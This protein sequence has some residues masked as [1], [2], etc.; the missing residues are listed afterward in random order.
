MH[1][2]S[3]QDLRWVKIEKIKEKVICPYCG[4]GQKIQYT[5]DAKCWGVYVKCQARHCKKEFE[6]K[7]NADK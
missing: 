1:F 2:C 7:I 5:P 6:V 3:G 4:N